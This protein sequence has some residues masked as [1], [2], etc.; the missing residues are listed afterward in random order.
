MSRDVTD[1]VVQVCDFSTGLKDMVGEFIE[2]QPEEGKLGLTAVRFIPDLWGFVETPVGV[3]V[4]NED[5]E[6]IW[7]HMVQFVSVSVYPKYGAGGFIR[8]FFVWLGLLRKNPFES[9]PKWKLD[10]SVAIFTDNRAGTRNLAKF[11]KRGDLYDERYTN[12]KA[13][14]EAAVGGSQGDV[15]SLFRRLKEGSFWSE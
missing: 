1:I 13:I 2:Q 4:V 15:E 9:L 12:V 10:L 14:L 7:L 8:R 5:G 11:I 3:F 6:L